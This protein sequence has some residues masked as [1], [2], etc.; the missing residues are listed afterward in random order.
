[1]NYLLLLL[2]SLGREPARN[3]VNE[4]PTEFLAVA[5]MWEFLL[6][7][8]SNVLNLYLLVS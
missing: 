5:H 6:P 3:L 8:S 1:M 4:T 2:L 7:I